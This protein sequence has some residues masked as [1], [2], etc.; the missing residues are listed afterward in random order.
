MNRTKRDSHGCDL[1][2]PSNG[3]Y[4]AAM[5]RPQRVAEPLC[6]Q[7]Q[8]LNNTQGQLVRGRAIVQRGLPAYERA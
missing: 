8:R 3:T 5:R 4:A 7:R 6:H 2:P 1:R